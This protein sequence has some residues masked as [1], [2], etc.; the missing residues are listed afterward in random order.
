MASVLRLVFMLTLALYLTPHSAL[1][2][3]SGTAWGSWRAPEHLI[4]R[5]SLEFQQGCDRWDFPEP[6]KV[7]AT[8]RDLEAALRQYPKDTYLRWWQAMAL[9]ELGRYDEA[10]AK[11]QELAIPPTPLRESARAFLIAAVWKAGDYSRA[12]EYLKPDM[13]SILWHRFAPAVFAAVF[14]LVTSLVFVK[15]HEGK[16]LLL[17]TLVP[18]GVHSVKAIATLLLAWAIQGYPLMHSDYPPGAW[19]A[20]SANALTWL[21]LLVAARRF[22]VPARSDMARSE[23]SPLVHVLI[24]TAFIA[25]LVYAILGDEWRHISLNKVHLIVANVNV[26]FM[27]HAILGVTLGA[28]ATARFTVLTLYAT[29]RELFAR[30]WGKEGVDAAIL[31]CALL[32]ILISYGIPAS[33]YAVRQALLVSGW[34][35]AAIALWEGLPSRFS[36]YV[37]YVVSSALATFV[38]AF[39]SLGQVIR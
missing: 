1:A 15:H 14:A 4:R 2:Q 24:G 26:P 22:P 30:R 8:L 3:N 17:L 29:V 9:L 20:L 39:V 19:V 36:A 6:R 23:L 28:I 32:L 11:F 7:E 37:P 38:S 27:V 12:W 33:L 25:V 34:G 10:V 16:R 31:W 5:F 21:L 18:A 13:A 35:I